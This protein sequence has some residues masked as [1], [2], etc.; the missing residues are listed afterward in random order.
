MCGYVCIVLDLS[1]ECGIPMK[2]Q[3]LLTQSPPTNL[4][5]SWQRSK[6]SIRVCMCIYMYERKRVCVNICVLLLVFV[7]NLSQW[8]L[9][10]CYCWFVC[11]GWWFFCSWQFVRCQTKDENILWRVAK[12]FSRSLQPTHQVRAHSYLTVH[13]KHINS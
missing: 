7:W 2:L 10:H 13:Q 11:F 4:P 1:C 3:L 12:T 8:S 5:T 9:K 6:L